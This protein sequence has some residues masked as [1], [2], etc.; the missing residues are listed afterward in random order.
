MGDAILAISPGRHKLRVSVVLALIVAGTGCAWAVKLD[1]AACDN[2]R[3][4]LAGAAAIGLKADMERGPEW[5]IVNLPP[6]RLAAI[7]RMIEVQEQ[8]EFRCGMRPTAIAKTRDD[9]PG[10]PSAKPENGKADQANVAP[11]SPA[12][13]AST[14][15]QIPAV[16]TPP[17]PPG[18]TPVATDA[19]MQAAVTPAKAPPA[20]PIA[21]PVTQAAPA[22][23][24]AATATPAPPALT[25]AT[26]SPTTATKSAATKKKSRR[27]SSNG[28]VP[29]GDVNPLALSPSGVR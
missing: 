3:T 7:K 11:Q 12:A 9:K 29:P 4:E 17:T 24:P 23:Q 8:L 20:A 26:K 19:T 2:L 15:A 10:A 22:T 14:A 1:K 27:E 28:Y 16:P 25:P 21:P 5:A 13:N 18:K 6:E